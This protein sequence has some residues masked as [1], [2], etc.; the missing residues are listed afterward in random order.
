M[1]A[2]LAATV[3]QHAFGRGHD[4]RH[5]RVARQSHAQG[6]AKGLED[7]LGLV[8]RVVTAQVIDMQSHVC[9][10]HKPLEKLK[11]QVDQNTENI[12]ELH[13]ILFNQNTIN[14]FG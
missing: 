5:R 14:L 2:T 8:V 3:L 6:A 1:T 12:K 10:I 9:V 13:N 11:K 4:I 7:R